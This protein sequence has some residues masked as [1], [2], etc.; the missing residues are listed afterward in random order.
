MVIFKTY[1]D[2]LQISAEEDKDMLNLDDQ[3]EDALKLCLDDFPELNVNEMAKEE[4]EAL[5]IAS[6]YIKDKTKVTHRR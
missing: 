6:Q 4:R 5:N 1:A 3:L 2:M